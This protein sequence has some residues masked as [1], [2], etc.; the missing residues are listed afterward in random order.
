MN[1]KMKIDLRVLNIIN[2]EEEKKRKRKKKQLNC[3]FF[4]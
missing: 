2:F 1:M 4:V 3:D